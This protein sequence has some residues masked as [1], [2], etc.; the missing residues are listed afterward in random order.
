MENLP[1][2]NTFIQ[3]FLRHSFID[4][5]YIYIDRWSIIHLSVG[6]MLGLFFAVYYPRKFSW[7]I[8]LALLIVYEIFEV[9]LT[10]ILF[11]SETPT[12]TVWDLII[13][14]IGFFIFYFIFYK[15]E[16]PQV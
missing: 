15:K 5:P 12:D 8:V 4:L 16:T 14:M 6:L 2:F 9:F 11:V 13:G 1:I 3:D 10:G 7:L